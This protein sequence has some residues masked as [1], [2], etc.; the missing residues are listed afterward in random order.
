MRTLPSLD[1][2]YQAVS[3]LNQVIRKT[4]WDF[5]KRLSAMINAS[6]FLKREDLQ[7]IRSFKIRGAYNKIYSLSSEERIGGIV[8]ASAGNHAQGFAFSCQKLKIQGDVYMPATTPQQKVAQVRRFGGDQI[9]V[10]LKGDTYDACQRHA[11]KVS[12]SE[13]K[14]FIHP[15]DDYKVIEGQATVAL[16]ILDQSTAPLDYIFVPIG[17]GGLISGVLTVM[18]YLSPKTKIIGVEPEGAPS[19][20]QALKAGERVTLKK[21]DRFVDGAAVRQVGE[22]PFEICNAQL[23]D[24]VTVHEGKICQT[25]LD[26]YNQDGIVAEPAGAL[27]IAGLEVMQ[28]DFKDKQIA[29]LLCGGNNDILRMPEISERA[30]LHASLKHYFLID[31]PQRAGALKEF[32]TEILGPNDDITHFEFSKKSYRSNAPAVVGI[33]LKEATDFSLLVERMKIHNFKFDYL[34]EKQNLFQF[35]I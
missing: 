33:K 4:P 12:K 34:N 15:F 3:F 17:G 31:F 28:G 35:L 2:V 8:C 20:Q 9:R 24:I 30:L 21:M 1:G 5:N 14:T 18:K 10:V 16:E 27:A 22:I 11:L 7:Q 19:M 13:G 32:V 6:V 29:V 26:L 23:D 25:I